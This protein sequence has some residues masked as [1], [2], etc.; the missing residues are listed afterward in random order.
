[1][2]ALF[3]WPVAMPGF[4]LATVSF[5][6]VCIERAELYNQDHIGGGVGNETENFS[7]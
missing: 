7:V 6:L 4:S 3:E 2:L 1:M 5:P